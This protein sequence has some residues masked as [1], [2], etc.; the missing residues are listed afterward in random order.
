MQIDIRDT[1][2]PEIESIIFS[3][4]SL[5]S[6]T[7]AFEL[8]LN[9]SCTEI[10]SEES[11]VN[12]DSKEDALNLI[13]ALQKAIEL[14]NWGS[15]PQQSTVPYVADTG[16]DMSNAENWKVG[17]I[18]KATTQGYNNR[19]GVRYEV[20]QVN[21]EEIRYK[22]LEDGYCSEEFVDKDEL[23]WLSANYKFIYR[24]IVN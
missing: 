22:C 13:K 18:I 17:D 4:K 21:S 20:I 19:L 23:G 5:K 12:I 6:G 2:P 9:G 15:A 1:N 7:D 11:F 8:F 10:R 24:P 14:G 3:D 16:E